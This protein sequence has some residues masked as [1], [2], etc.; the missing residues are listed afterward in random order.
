MH[1]ERFKAFEKYFDEWMS[2]SDYDGTLAGQA[3]RWEPAK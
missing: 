3:E 2:E 1:E